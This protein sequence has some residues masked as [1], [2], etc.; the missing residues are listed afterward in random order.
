MIFNAQ[1]QVNPIVS[2]L[3]VAPYSV[4]VCACTHVSACGVCTYTYYT[5]CQ[6]CYCCIA[7]AQWSVIYSYYWTPQWT[8]GFR[9]TSLLSLHC[10]TLKCT[11][12]GPTVITQGNAIITLSGAAIVS[13][14]TNSRAT[15]G[16]KPYS[17]PIGIQTQVPT[18]TNG[19]HIVIITATYLGHLWCNSLLPAPL[20]NSHLS[21]TATNLWPIAVIAQYSINTLW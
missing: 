21:I 10:H 2:T 14:T 16:M 9:N 17:T 11:Y 18:C 19:T 6:K 1:Y 13:V 3:E 8:D 5:W 12:L 7:S 4:Y 20:S 15:E